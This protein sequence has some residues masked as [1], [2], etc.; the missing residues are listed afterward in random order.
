[1][2]TTTSMLETLLS[3]TWILALALSR[4][5]ILLCPTSN[6]MLCCP[7]RLTNCLLFTL[8]LLFL[9]TLLLSPKPHLLFPLVIFFLLLHTASCI[10]CLP[11]DLVLVVATLNHVY[12][13][14]V[15]TKGRR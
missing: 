4:F 2:S 13:L 14:E 5:F 7:L 3:P 15:G 11:F 10:I 1:M 12:P 9:L 6:L 8:L